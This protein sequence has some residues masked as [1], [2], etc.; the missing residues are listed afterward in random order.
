MLLGQILLFMA[1]IFLTRLIL[2]GTS[3]QWA[4][5]II[6]LLALYHFQPL[7]PIRGLVFWFPTIMVFL[8]ILS[9]TIIN[10]GN[11]SDYIENRIALGLIFGLLLAIGA[12]QY[13][14]TRVLDLLT[15]TPGLPSILVGILLIAAAYSLARH[16][17]NFNQMPILVISAIILIFLV[18]LKS[19]TLSLAASQILRRLNGQSVPLA[20]ASDI[21]WVGYSYFSF[22]ILHTLFDRKRVAGLDVSLREYFLYLIFFPTILAGPIDRVKHFTGQIRAEIFPFSKG[23]LVEGIFRISRGVLYKFILADSLALFSLSSQSVYQIS[24]AGW[25][26]ILVYSFAFRIFFDFAGYTEIAIGL[27][28]LAGIQLPENFR[29]PYRSRN[30]TQFWNNWHI[31][32]TQWFRTYYFNPLTRQLRT[33]LKSLNPAGLIF[34]T[35]TTTMVLVGLWHGISWNFVLWGLWNGL[36]LFI[37]N[38]WSSIL[39][40]KFEGIQAF[41]NSRWGSALSVVLNFHYIALGWVWFALPTPGESVMVFRRLIGL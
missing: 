25:A 34:F 40:P 2:K 1:V 31:T 14:N 9:W 32:L 27:G 5:Y 30:I 23:D 37:H 29:Q 19:N 7:S 18:I 8:S 11:A 20:A 39:L 22:R 36:G 35:Q 10:S 24:H 21:S 12:S 3:Y 41:V 38:R 16:R 28:R 26:W 15:P 33:R 17:N 13:V 6:S 4:L